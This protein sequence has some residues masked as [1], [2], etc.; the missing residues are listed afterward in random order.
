MLKCAASELR[1]DPDVVLT[2]VRQDAKA[3]MH[4]DPELLHDR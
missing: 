2:A 3:L 1:R 4:A